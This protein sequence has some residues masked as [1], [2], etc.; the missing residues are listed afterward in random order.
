MIRLE[1]YL[2]TTEHTEN[3]KGNTSNTCKLLIYYIF[4]K[5]Y[6]KRLD[7]AKSYGIKKGFING[8][9]MGLLFLVINS[10]YALGF[11]YGWTLTEE[12]DPVT[13]LPKFTVGE[14]LLVFFNIIIGVFSLGNAGPLIGTIASARAAAY[15]IFNIIDRVPPIDTLATESGAKPTELIGNIEFDNVS[16]CY[17]ARKEAKILSGISYTIKTGQKVAL[18]GDSGCGSLFYHSF[19]S[20]KLMSMIFRK[21][22]LCS[23]DSEIL[24]SR[25]WS[26]ETG[27]S[28]SQG[29]KFEMAER[30]NRRG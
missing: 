22:N 21:V 6:E 20:S 14:I 13:G 7:D 11:W 10:A 1:L 26:S 12:L 25:Q 2:P 15:E 28:E 23:V 8:G 19:G 4:M 16:F 9:M 30:A 17:P 29:L 27:Q 5:R 24:R 18:V 3:T